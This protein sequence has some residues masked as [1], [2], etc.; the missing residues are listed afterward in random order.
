M[1]AISVI[2]PCY[3]VAPYIGNAVRSL[4]AQTHT[5]WEAILVSDDQQDYKA[6]LRTQGICDPR[7]KFTSTGGIGT[8][9]SNARNVGLQAATSRFIANLDGDDT[10]APTYLETLLPYTE[11]YGLCLSN[12]RYIDDSAQPHTH[13]QHRQS[14]PVGLQSL[15]KLLLTST[16]V[17]FMYDSERLPMRWLSELTVGEDT[18]FLF[19]AYEYLEAMY[20]LPDPLY[21]YHRRAGSLTNSPETTTHF[22][23]A[24]YR[25]LK[26]IDTGAILTRNRCV[27]MVTRMFFEQSVAAEQEYESALQSDLNSDFLFIFKERLHQMKMI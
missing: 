22:I 16:H 27:A 19:G 24:K 1:H 13:N 10:I 3:K 11:A 23:E 20:S 9:A 21:H 17:T 26:L 15:V 14:G 8:R 5:N 25:I 18:L 7:L 4:L 6:I 12:Y 2:I